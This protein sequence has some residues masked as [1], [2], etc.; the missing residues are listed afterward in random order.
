MLHPCIN[1]PP[2]PSSSGSGPQHHSCSGPLPMVLTA[3]DH[4][5]ALPPQGVNHRAGVGGLHS[6]WGKRCSSG[7]NYTSQGRN[8]TFLGELISMSFKCKHRA[9]AAV[10]LPANWGFSAE[11]GQEQGILCSVLLVP[12]RLWFAKASSGSGAGFNNR[13]GV[14]SAQTR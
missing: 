5:T 3:L 2:G 7:S 14:E 11:E 12:P 6:V 9:C 13:Y 1:P 10:L 4:R 8:S